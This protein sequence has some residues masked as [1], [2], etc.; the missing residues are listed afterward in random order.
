MQ[1][2]QF[3]PPFLIVKTNHDQLNFAVEKIMDSCIFKANGKTLK[4]KIICPEIIYS[5][6]PCDTN[7]LKNLMS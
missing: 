5:H 1:V 3:H 6:Q 4:N 7:V 2:F